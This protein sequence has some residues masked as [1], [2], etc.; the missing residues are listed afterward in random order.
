MPPSKYAPDELQK[1]I[2]L[3]LMK[4][5]LMGDIGGQTLKL[6]YSA[7]DKNISALLKMESA[8]DE[9][10]PEHASVFCDGSKFK[11]CFNIKSL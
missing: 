6:R 10:N 9:K 3:P 11:L 2:F 4:K 5:A 1:S 8:P 7:A